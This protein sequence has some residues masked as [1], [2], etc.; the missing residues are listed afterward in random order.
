[1]ALERVGPLLDAVGIEAEAFGP[2]TLR[3]LALPPES[4]RLTW[5]VGFEAGAVNTGFALPLDLLRAIAETARS[6]ATK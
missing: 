2:E 1:M 4:S 3:L 6:A 5:K